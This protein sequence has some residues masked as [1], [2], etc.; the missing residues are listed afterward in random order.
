MFKDKTAVWVVEYIFGTGLVLAGLTGMGFWRLYPRLWPV[1]LFII[2]LGV[3]LISCASSM[4]QRMFLARQIDE[5][6]KQIPDIE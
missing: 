2:C 5:L 4:R 3:I 1:P 6:A